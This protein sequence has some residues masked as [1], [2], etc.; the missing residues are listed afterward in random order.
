[1]TKFDPPSLF[2]PSVEKNV[3]PLALLS[4]PHLQK[5]TSILTTRSLKDMCI[6]SELI[7]TRRHRRCQQ[8]H[9]A[10]PDATTP[11]DIDH[12]AKPDTT[13][14][15]DLHHDRDLGHDHDLHP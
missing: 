6:N 14:H 5:I 1:M 7:L 15:I 4:T 13:T 3:D 8:R 11:T 9:L 10:K 2:Q 12:L